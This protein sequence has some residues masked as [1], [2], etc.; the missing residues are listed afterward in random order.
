[1][2]TTCK[3]CGKDYPP[4]HKKDHAKTCIGQSKV[5][6]S[7]PK[8]PCIRTSPVEHQNLTDNETDSETTASEG[9]SESDVSHSEDEEIFGIESS[10]DA[11][12]VHITC[13]EDDRVTCPIESCG[14][15][16]LKQNS[17]K[18]NIFVELGSIISLV[19]FAQSS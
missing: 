10:Q 15:V 14:S 12:R 3:N 7:P 4:G 8:R 5:D 6:Y 18:L 16:S 11:D 9:S 19:A 2:R 17:S 1:M 13:K